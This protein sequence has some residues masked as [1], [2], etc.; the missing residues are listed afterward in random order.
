VS[1]VPLSSVRAIL[2]RSSVEVIFDLVDPFSN[3]F[4]SRLYSELYIL[5]PIASAF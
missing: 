2:E 3:I 5:N 1:E 4:M